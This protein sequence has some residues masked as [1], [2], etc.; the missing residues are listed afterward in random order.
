MTFYKLKSCL[1]SLV[2]LAMIFT[3]CNFSKGSYKDL[4]TGLSY[5]YNGF[6]P[7][8]IILLD[9]YNE[10]LR[11]NKLPEVSLL[12]LLVKNINNYTIENGRVYLGCRILVTDSEGKEA[13]SIEDLYE[14]I[15]GIPVEEMDNLVFQVRLANPIVS[16]KTYH[17]SYHLY[18]KKNE[19]NRLNAS[20]DIEVTPNE[21]DVK[22]TSEGLTVDK[23][24]LAS[25]R[26]G[27]LPKAK[28]KKGTNA[29]FVFGGL[30]GFT[31][32]NGKVFLG[33]KLVVTG[34]NGEVML[35][36][37]DLFENIS[38][39]GIAPEESQRI[40]A[41]VNYG[42]PMES[43]NTYHV[44]ILIFDKKNSALW[45]MADADVEVVK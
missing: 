39:E 45:L 4:G 30:K 17:V 38:T 6:S 42:S 5:T 14:K 13:L 43:G 19:K 36:N 33:C 15:D 20:V 2:G 21:V 32:E 34:E 40:T 27:E 9:G 12:Q 3:S 22:Q 11:N 23:V 28:V 1:L 44:N 7:D 26:E 24:F 31:E 37:E 8:K 18:D 41:I 10:P 35:M 16:G 25:E 29:A